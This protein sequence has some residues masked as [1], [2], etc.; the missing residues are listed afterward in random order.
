MLQQRL[1]KFSF[2]LMLL[3]SFFVPVVQAQEL[4]EPNIPLGEIEI[5]PF[6]VELSVAKGQSTQTEIEV[7]NNSDQ[8][9]TVKVETKDFLP[10][11]RGEP[12]FVPD[13][14]INDLTYSLASWIELPVA[15]LTLAPEQ[16]KIVTVKVSPPANAEEGTHY[17]A[18]LFS[19]QS[20]AGL[21]GVGVSQSVG[22]IFLLEYGQA[23]SSGDSQLDVSKKIS[24]SNQKIDFA[25]HFINT[26]NVHVQPKGEVHIKNIFGQVVASPDINKFAANVLPQ[27]DRTFVDSWYPSALSFGRY[28]AESV[29]T[30]GREKL[31]DR[32]VVILWVFPW[33]WILL[34]ALLV[35]VFAWYILHG[36]HWHKRKI[37][38]KHNSSS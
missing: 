33:Y 34:L 38:Q 22:S 20:P 6:L 30:Y 37:L 15:R 14:E 21:S 11:Q 35:L 19:Y 4:P 23:R 3:G 24:F 16:K 36:R 31:E 26:G 10:G 27:S 17:G 2:L 12:R 32:D 7:R 25:S 18:V 28:K 29:V 5:S 9:L 1:I 13:E 8:P